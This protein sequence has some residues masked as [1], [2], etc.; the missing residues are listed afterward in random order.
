MKN[1]IFIALC[2][3]GYRMHA[4]D[5]YKIDSAK[6]TLFLDEMVISANKIEEPR[7]HINQQIEVLTNEKIRQLNAPTT[8]DLLSNSGWVAIQK[9]QQ[10]G[11]SVQLRGFEASRVLLMVDG[12]RMNNLIYRAGH[13]Q[14]LITTDNN[15]MERVEILFGPSSTVYGS[16]ALGGVIHLYTKNPMLASEADVKFSGNL[17]TRY[18]SVNDEKTRHLDF[19]INSERFGS[20]TSF[21]YSDF[22]DLKMGER[23]NPQLGEQLWLRNNYTVR[24]P[25]NQSDVLVTNSDPFVQKQSGY[26][27]YDLIQK[28]LFKSGNRISHLFNIQYSTSSDIFRYDRL[29]DV[30]GTGLRSAEWYYGPQKRLLSSYNL[31]VK[32]LGSMADVLS[33]TASFQDIEES[34]NDR[35]FNN[36]NL[37]SRIENVNVFGITLDF[38]KSIK[39][40]DIR[41]GLDGQFNTLKSTA[42]A[43]N[44]V[45]GVQSNSD[46]R[47]PDGDN[48]MN[49]VAGYFTHT[50]KINP[51]FTL[52]DGVR[53]GGSWLHAAFY[54]KSFFPFPFNEVDQNNLLSSA[55]LGLIYAPTSW[56]FS[57]MIS[58]GFRAPN[59]DDLGKVFESTP[60]NVI[61]PN[62]DLESEKTLNADL[63]ITKFIGS[64]TRI[65]T[66]FYAT[67]FSD[68]IVT[69]PSTFNGQSTINYDGTPSQVLANQNKGK[70]Y[71]LGYNIGLH[72]SITDQVTAS[73]SFNYTKGRVLNEG[74]PET[75][76]DHIPPFFGRISIRYNSEKLK[77]EI[78]SNFNGWKTLDN[79]SNSGEDNLN[80]ATPRGMPS[81]YTLNLR[82]SYEFNSIFAIQVGVD[83]LFDLQY[84]VFASGINAPGRNIFGTLRIHF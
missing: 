29:T 71:I 54:D 10:G 19:N 76:L 34:R 21:T 66:A 26:R 46:T 58:S 67:Q 40:S 72:T 60:G 61:V 77:T 18:G 7:R 70:A 50:Y 56:K 28:F 44:I 74:G 63:A 69:L 49:T 31:K 79:Y 41:Y 15:S 17:M 33:L 16:D 27:Q 36:N 20:F 38:K 24:A 3:L 11:G 81:W 57:I 9:S 68:A 8:A 62:P 37:R 32:D 13:L 5:Q 23:T 73:A 30:Q 47:Y 43:T 65:E 51:Q 52:T 2:C 75:P 78:F 59:I 82:G 14:N 25:D 55:N 53:I 39:R 6:I 45:T 64:N 84:R 1:F 83:N 4:Q 12:V 42:H 80:Y 48:S 22:G 35:R